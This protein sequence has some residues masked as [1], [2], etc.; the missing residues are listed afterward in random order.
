MLKNWTITTQAVRGSASATDAVMA[1]ER[2]LLAANHPN[3]RTTESII[4]LIGNAQTSQRIALLGEEFRLKQQ[5]SRKGGRP[6]SSFAIEYCLVLPKLTHSR[7]TP[8]QW[9]Q[10]LTD[11]CKAL[12]KLLELKPEEIRI[13][14]QQIR[15]VLH[16]QNQSGK[17]GAGD[18]VH[19]I[20]GKV[21]SC[22]SGS[23]RV[24]KELQKKGGL[25][26]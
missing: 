22:S 26:F 9:K 10:V 6:I 12:V 21:L 4:S 8:E 16:Q 20:I 18:H 25:K 14:R 5:L 1:R 13:F 2:Y 19:L 24:L 23:S 7:P 11:C 15:A 17:R 3:H